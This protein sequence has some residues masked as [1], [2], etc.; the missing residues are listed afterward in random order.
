MKSKTEVCWLEGYASIFKVN[1]PSV[2]NNII[3]CSV[4]VCRYYVMTLLLRTYF[5]IN[6]SEIR[7]HVVSFFHELLSKRAKSTSP[8]NFRA[9][10]RGLNDH[11]SLSKV[12]DPRV[13]NHVTPCNQGR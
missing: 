13:F 10:T 11:A 7:D 3:S 12:I 9:S 5:K 2:F 8:V 4:C 6:A 1:D